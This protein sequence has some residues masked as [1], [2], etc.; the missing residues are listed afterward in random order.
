MRGEVFKLCF[1]FVGKSDNEDAEEDEDVSSKEP[2]NIKDE[3]VVKTEPKYEGSPLVEEKNNVDEEG[4]AKA[5]NNENPIEPVKVAIKQ[6]PQK[7]VKV[8][9]EEVEEDTLDKKE[10]KPETN[11]SPKEN[12]TSP[13]KNLV[14]NIV[15]KLEKSETVTAVKPASKTP[16]ATLKEVTW[17]KYS[18]CF[19]KWN[20]LIT[21]MFWAE[22]CL[23]VEI[24]TKRYQFSLFNNNKISLQ[25]FSTEKKVTMQYIILSLLKSKIVR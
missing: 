5:D 25:E 3:I 2:N 12:N 18:F 23:N 9:E 7:S 17:F 15:P 6:S 16:D 19:M 20:R 14:E 24:L 21:I 11:N 8:K 22:E 4:E 1:W 10:K 13:V